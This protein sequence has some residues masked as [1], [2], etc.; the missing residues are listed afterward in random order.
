MGGRHNI[1]CP[2]IWTFAALEIK[3]SVEVIDLR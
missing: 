2:D 1:I 3:E